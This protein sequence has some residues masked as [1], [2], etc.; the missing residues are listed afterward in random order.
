MSHKWTEADESYVLKHYALAGAEQC[1]RI[2]GIPI[3][4]VKKKAQK[5][6]AASRTVH[7]DADVLKLAARPQ[8]VRGIE[9]PGEASNVSRSFTRLVKANKLIRVQI[10]FKHVLYF[11]HQKDADAAKPVSTGVT[12]RSHHRVNGWGRDDPAYYDP[13]HPP[14][15]TIAPAPVPCT[16]TNT[17]L[18]VG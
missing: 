12:I 13:E 14:K 2:L 7:V 5:L 18:Q 8:G 9:L 15:I 10:K 16:R 3:G 1:A 17:Y 11:V 4:A 6:K